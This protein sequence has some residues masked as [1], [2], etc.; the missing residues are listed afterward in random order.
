MNTKIM[1][2]NGQFFHIPKSLQGSYRIAIRLQSP[3]TGHY[4][5]NWFYNNTTK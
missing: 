5:Y 2:M 3:S 1:S 4:S